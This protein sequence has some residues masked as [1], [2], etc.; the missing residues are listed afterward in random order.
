M[1]AMH[2]NGKVLQPGLMGVVDQM[3]ADIFGSDC[4]GT[5]QLVAK[6]QVYPAV[7]SLRNIVALKRRSGRTSDELVS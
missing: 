3:E 4:T 7:K 5:G 1:H 6:G 2:L